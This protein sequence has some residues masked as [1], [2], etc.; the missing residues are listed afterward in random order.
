MLSE[1]LKKVQQNCVSEGEEEKE[2][3]K[4]VVLNQGKLNELAQDLDNLSDQILLEGIDQGNLGM[5][6]F[7]QK[8]S[9][10]KEI[11]IQD[12]IQKKKEDGNTETDE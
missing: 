3:E 12:L 8:V 2:E 7:L 9:E 11:K 6:V 10:G 4:S 1:Y 5:E